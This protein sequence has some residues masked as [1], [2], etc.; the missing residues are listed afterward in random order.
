[1]DVIIELANVSKSYNEIKA[2]ENLSFKLKKGE[3]LGFLG[4]NGAGKTTAMKMI[5]GYMPPDTGTIKVKNEDI[6]KDPVKARISIGYLPENNPLYLDMT[7]AE[8]LNF[9]AEMRGIENREK[10]IDS[11]LTKCGIKNVSHRII[12]HLSKGYKQRVGLAQAIIHDPEIL[13][14]DEPVNGLDPK[15][16]TEIRNLIKELG[17]E[18]TVILC[19]HILSEVEAVADRVLIINNGKIAADD[20]IENLRERS[21]GSNIFVL[22]IIDETADIA[23]KLNTLENV[24]KVEKVHSGLYR[25]F[26]AGNKETGHSIFV[27]AAS[28][29][30]K[31]VQLYLEGNSLENM[32]LN[33]TEGGK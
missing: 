4:P 5:T 13:I 26:A 30:W 33:L 17:K 2:V 31:V 7:V 24:K 27:L 9:I 20:T 29:N 6:L 15:Q 10:A 23:E 1:M 14:L 12:N 8:Y 19:S 18:K 32:F 11:A 16:I 21:K 22:D 28:N 3:I 25:I